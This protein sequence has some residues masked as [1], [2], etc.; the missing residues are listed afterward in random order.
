[1]QSNKSA[2]D[3]SVEGRTERSM[4]YTKP[5][6]IRSFQMYRTTVV[7]LPYSTFSL[8]NISSFPLYIH[9]TTMKDEDTTSGN[10]A[11]AAV[12][13]T[14]T[15]TTANSVGHK[16]KK[17]STPTEGYICKHCGQGGHWIQQCPQAP[18]R[19]KKKK[20]NP[21]HTHIPGIDP[22]PQDVALA[23]QLQQLVPPL[24][25]CGQPG[26]LKKVKRSK[27]AGPT[28]TAI[29]KYFFFC[30]KARDDTTKCRFAKLVDV[31][32]TPTRKTTFEEHGK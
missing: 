20:K 9:Y 27:Y 18:K 8:F 32:N 7:L 4:G 12:E 21:N 25:N 11:A 31:N 1:M 28:S 17:L 10:D 13:H 30:A 15:T 2:T 24:C 26:R 3:P 14:T 29:G 6:T 16:R 5:R 22:S 19:Q 23:R